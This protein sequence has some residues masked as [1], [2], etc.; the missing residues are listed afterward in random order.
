L[1]TNF[2][3]KLP[4]DVLAGKV[5]GAI[6][7]LL[8]EGFENGEFLY[9]LDTTLPQVT[10]RDSVVVADGSRS[11]L[12]LRGRAGALGSTLL[13]YRPRDGVDP[14]FL[15]Y[16]LQS[17]YAFT[18]T[19]TIGGAVPHLDSCLLDRLSLYLPS[20]R[21][22]EEAI[23]RRLRAVDDALVAAKAKLTAARRLK[24]ALMQELFTRG[25][26]GR[27][28]RFKVA[29]VFRTGFE[30]PDPWDVAPLRRSV[31]KVEY[32]TN[33]ASND[34]KHGLPVVAIP[35]VVAPRFH[36]GDCSYVEVSEQEAEALRLQPDDV[37][38]IRTN[39]NA[40]YIGKSTVIGEEAT[41]THIIFA[42]YLIRIQTDKSKLSGRY[43]N[44]FLA[45]PLG[46][47]QCLAMA[48]TSAG[49]HNI[50]SRAIRQFVLPR[51]EPDEQKEIVALLDAAEDTIE[52]VLRELEALD[53]LKRSLLQNLL[54]GRIRTRN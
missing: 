1:A 23:G 40:E 42:S 5:D 31:T 11:G 43:L 46:R 19:A 32:G 33:V 4:S 18:N 51:P 36:L 30:T 34:G 13:C 9:T 49:N 47:R 41:D 3:G 48:N 29:R 54:T 15:Y 35:E 21:E 8:V 44:Y 14:D 52:A 22:E 16:L 27:H 6:P 17:F 37:L 24:V 12:T 38:L 45:S 26:P 20:T 25:V 2:K 10:E 39:G 53:R 7:Y 28:A 50:G